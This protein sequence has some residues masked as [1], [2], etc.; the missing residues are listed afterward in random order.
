[1]TQSSVKT[2]VPIPNEGVSP[3]PTVFDVVSAPHLSMFPVV[4]AS[5]SPKC[6][7]V[8]HDAVAVGN[9]TAAALLDDPADAAFHV[10]PVVATRAYAP[11]ETSVP[12]PASVGAA[13]YRPT[14]TVGMVYAVFPSM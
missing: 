9:V 5:N 12:P 7:M 10:A 11:P 6:V 2:R 1:M 8:P 13:V 3:F 14:Y 4:E